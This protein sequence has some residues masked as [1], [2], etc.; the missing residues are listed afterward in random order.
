MYGGRAL[1][2]EYLTGGTTQ[3]T[4]LE[5]MMEV[6]PGYQSETSIHEASKHVILQ[7]RHVVHQ[8]RDRSQGY[9]AVNKAT[10]TSFELT[11]DSFSSLSGSYAC[12]AC[13]A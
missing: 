9:C 13:P 3:E 12:G 11:F 2:T 10:P 1:T 6:V 4:K 8:A 5:I 7:W